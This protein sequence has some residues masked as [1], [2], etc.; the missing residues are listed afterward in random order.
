M[1]LSIR[2]GIFTYDRELT[3]LCSTC[4]TV[5]G[6][7][8]AEHGLIFARAPGTPRDFLLL[9]SN[10]DRHS[11]RQCGFVPTPRIVEPDMIR[12]TAAMLQEFIELHNPTL[13]A[14]RE[15]FPAT[16]NYGALIREDLEIVYP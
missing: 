14:F 16:P 11:C 10:L 2:H 5:T 12:V 9:A 6:I 3:V 15:E 4:G 7:V 13:T 8:P 1:N